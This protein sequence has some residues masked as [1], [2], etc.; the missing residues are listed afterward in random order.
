MQQETKHYQQVLKNCAK[1][2]CI[3]PDCDNKV[4]QYDL[5]SLEISKNR[6]YLNRY[7]SKH[8][9][10]SIKTPFLDATKDD[11]TA[12]YFN[13]FCCKHLNEYLKT[14]KVLAPQLEAL[15]ININDNL[16]DHKELYETYVNY[17]YRLS[18]AEQV[19]LTIKLRRLMKLSLIYQFELSWLL[20]NLNNQQHRYVTKK[21]ILSKPI[22]SLVFNDI[23]L[24]QLTPITFQA[25]N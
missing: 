5:Y 16:I 13:V 12:Y 23:L 20:N 2:T 8:F 11:K 3:L 10:K 9:F 18:V 14:D 15:L 19:I 25:I 1:Q 7:Y 21:I 6:Y 17:Y 24:V 22:N 4:S